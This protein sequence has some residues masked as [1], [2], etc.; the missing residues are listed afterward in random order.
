MID[1]ERPV[2]RP[3]EFFGQRN[4][5]RRIFSRIG[6]ERPQSIAVIGG[7][8]VGKTSLLNFIS[9]PKVIEENLGD[10]R[11]YLF[12][13]VRIEDDHELN[14]GEFLAGLNNR[15]GAG[16]LEGETPYN[17]LQRRVEEAHREGRSIIFFFDDFHFITRNE[18][19]PLEFFSFLRSLAN[20]FNLAYVTSSFLELQKLCVAKDIEES[21]FFNIFTNVPLG[22]LGEE[23]AWAFLSKLTGWD[24]ETV[25]KVVAW[26][27]PLPYIIKLI[28]REC[29]NR[30]PENNQYEKLFLPLF[31]E[32]FT[33]ILSIL[34]R[35]A[36]KPLKDLVKGKSTDP[37]D[38]HYLKPLI[39]HRFLLDDDGSISFFSEAFKLFVMKNLTPA[40]LK[41]NESYL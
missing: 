2:E 27:G 6:A 29:A 17:A 10:P 36:F 40:F 24:K 37:R 9:D 26:A 14:A 18:N 13:K 8:K 3:D 1:A 20:N 16:A 28:A 4:I 11:K 30:P 33:L 5:V 12:V 35:E 39:R 25:T 41:G 32:Y 31:K 19:F 15:L 22:L 23:D 34:G 7:R 21:P 38:S